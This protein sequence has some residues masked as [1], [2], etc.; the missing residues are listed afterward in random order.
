MSM[1]LTDTKV[2]IMEA[3]KIKI[4]VLAKGMVSVRA[5]EVGEVIII[6]RLGKHTP[7]NKTH[8]SV[9]KIN[10]IEIKVKQQYRRNR[11]RES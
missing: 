6:I 5:I 7:K 9:T 4:M 11:L 10:Q 2:S 1:N 3:D 8:A